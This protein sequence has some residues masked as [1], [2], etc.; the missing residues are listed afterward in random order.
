MYL[1]TTAGRSSD[2]RGNIFRLWR[3]IHRPQNN[4]GQQDNDALDP[5]HSGPRT[6]ADRFHNHRGEQGQQ[7]EAP[8]HHASLGAWPDQHHPGILNGELRY[9]HQQYQ[10]ALPALQTG[11]TE[12]RARVLRNRSHDTVAGDADHGHVHAMVARW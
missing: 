9:R 6:R 12:D 2:N 10:V 3:G 1:F 8:F 5:A 11:S 7:Q 4:Q